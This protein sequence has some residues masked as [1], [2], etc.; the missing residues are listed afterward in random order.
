MSAKDDKRNPPLAVALRYD[1][2]RPPVVTAK[3]EGFVAEEILRLAQE[4]DI[5]VR[6]EPDLVHM[7]SRVRLGEEI[8]RSLYVAVAQVIA[9]AYMLKGKTPGAAASGP[10]GTGGP[11][12]PR[13]NAPD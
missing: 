11:A 9:F 1:G 4:H 5:P 2:T 8:P 12:H 7:L 3:G 13:L 6:D 10:D